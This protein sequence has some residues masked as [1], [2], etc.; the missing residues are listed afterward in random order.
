MVKTVSVGVE[1]S[2]GHSNI[3]IEVF[4]CPKCDKIGIDY[5]C[6]YCSQCGVK[7]E[8]RQA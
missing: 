7:I 5:C 4:E 2:R 8:W 3:Y 6:K 1:E